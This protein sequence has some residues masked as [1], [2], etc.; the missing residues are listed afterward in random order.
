ME[1]QMQKRGTVTSLASLFP[2]EET[3]KASER[4]QN[5][6]SERWEH[7]GQLKKFIADNANLINLVQTLPNELHHNIM[8][9]FGKAA[10]FPG[11][12]IHS[13]EFMVLLGEGYYAER[14]SKQ[15]IEILKRRGKILDCQVE[16]LKAEIQDLKAE[17]SF[18]YAT[19][20][21]AKDGLVQIVEDYV[22][23]TYAHDVSEPGMSETDSARSFKD[24]K[25]GIKVDDEEFK[26]IFS[27]MDELE[28]EEEAE[29]ATED[30]EDEKNEDDSGPSIDRA[31]EVESSLVKDSNL[32]SVHKDE[33]SDGK[34]PVL[35]KSTL[36]EKALELPRN[37]ETV[38]AP[39]MSGKEAFTGSIVEH[40]Q[41][42]ESSQMEQSST[43]GSKPVSRFK[44]RRQ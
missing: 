9:S 13:N 31:Q 28:K 20:A 1:E 14:T 11:K 19:A 12:L 5:A 38:Q 15:T 7:L 37:K 34:A 2:P 26:R 23:E 24:E 44:L 32:L 41:N 10:F 30:E 29:N 21:E 6:I 8:V 39:A 18:F 27:I 17:A 22:E 3:H 43:R 4:V 25:S 16:S 35:N 40:T 36:T 42:L 33:S